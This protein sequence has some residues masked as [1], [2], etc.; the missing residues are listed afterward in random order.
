MTF[1]RHFNNKADLAAELFNAAAATAMPRFVRITTMVYQDRD[2]VL[3]W[4]KALFEADYKNRRALRPFAQATVDEDSFTKRAQQL[5]SEIIQILGATIPTFA[6]DPDRPDER[7]RWLEAWLLIY[8]ILDQGNHAALNSGVATDPLV[9][10]ILAERFL[11][12]VVRS[13]KCEAATSRGRRTPLT[14]G[15]EFSDGVGGR[16]SG[17]PSRRRN[18]GPMA[19]RISAPLAPPNRRCRSTG[20]RSQCPQGALQS[21]AA[22]HQGDPQGGLRVA[23][24][25][26]LSWCH[27]L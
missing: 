11:Q 1:Y 9:I 26:Q 16:P 27:D 25:R 6:V 14:G 7:R 21:P 13:R 8:E 2:E 10:E 3:K 23:Q 22:G 12:F 24:L 5:I 19:V 18:H 17:A 15:R 20:N 4:I